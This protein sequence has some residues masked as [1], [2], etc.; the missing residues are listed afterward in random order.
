MLSTDSTQ[1]SLSVVRGSNSRVGFKDRRRNSIDLHMIN[2]MKKQNRTASETQFVIVCWIM[3]LDILIRQLKKKKDTENLRTFGGLILA[4]RQ[5]GCQ[6]LLSP[7][8]ICS[9]SKP[10]IFSHPFPLTMKTASIA[11][12][13]FFSAG[14]L[15]ACF[16]AASDNAVTYISNAPLGVLDRPSC[17]TI[18]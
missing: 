12:S 4:T 18:H 3:A 11:L 2:I 13:L 8:F 9:L 17:H 15:P 10:F 7:L 5:L 6:S 16:A 1:S 14:L